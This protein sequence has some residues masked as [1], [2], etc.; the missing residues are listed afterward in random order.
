MFSIIVYMLLN[1]LGNEMDGVR[2]DSVNFPPAKQEV[3]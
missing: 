1:I 2:T 3:I